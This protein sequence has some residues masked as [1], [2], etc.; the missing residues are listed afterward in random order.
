[1]KPQPIVTVDG[2]LQSVTGHDLLGPISIARQE[3]WCSCGRK[4]TASSA[5][6]LP[7]AWTRHH[8]SEAPVQAQLGKDADR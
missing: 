8:Q 6:G 5:A 4:I 2:E 3:A 1:M 7:Q